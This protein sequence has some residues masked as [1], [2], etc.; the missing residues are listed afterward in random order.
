LNPQA[1]TLKRELQTR[2]L[3]TGLI[4]G[5]WLV[6]KAYYGGI[7]LLLLVVQRQ[8]RALAIAGSVFG[9]AA[10]L[11]LAWLGPDVWAQ[12][13]AL[14]ASYRARPETAV[15]A[16]QS[17]HSLL[18]HL[19]HYDAQWNPAPLADWPGLVDLLWWGCVLIFG[20]VSFFALWQVTRRPPPYPRQLLP[21]ALATLLALLLAP[22]NEEYHY[23]LALFPVVIVGVS[24]WE[25]DHGFVVAALAALRLRRLK[26]L[27]QTTAFVVAI[28]LLGV[29]WLYAAPDPG[30]WAALLHY[31]RLAGALLLWLLTLYLLLQS[32]PTDA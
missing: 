29:P 17:L 30:G 15:L 11:T 21:P 2:E 26:P 7:F 18:M 20:G 25:R 1:H 28:L 19:F 22:V 3:L 27:L 5:L 14:A 16:Y 12:G 9:A 24:L 13:I 6:L 8:W 23:L 4:V 31:P 32:N 10:L